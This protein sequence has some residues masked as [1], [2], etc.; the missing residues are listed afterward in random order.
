MRAAGLP[1]A[2]V[3]GRGYRLESAP[4]LLDEA[5]IRGRLPAACGT[6]LAALEVAWSLDSTNSQL[7]RR[8]APACGTAVLLAERQT[9]GRGRRGRAW[10][11]PLAANVYLSASRRFSGGLSRLPGLSLVAG[12][13]TAEA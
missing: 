5:A 8:P 4:E 13:A 9:G 11:S 12:G 3:P 7:L 6:Q 1:V 2:A 10:A